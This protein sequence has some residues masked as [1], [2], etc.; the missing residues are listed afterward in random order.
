MYTTAQRRR[1]ALAASRASAALTILVAA[2]LSA[3]PTAFAHVGITPRQAAAGG[4][5][6]LSFG[7]PHGCDGS[8][9][10]RIAVQIPEGVVSVKPQVAPGWEIATTTGPYAEPVELH[11]DTLTEG[12]VEVVW[13]GGPLSDSHL[14][15]F[16]MSV[17]LPDAPGETIAFPVIQTCVEGETGWIQIAAASDSDEA[18]GEELEHPAPTIELLAASGGHGE[19]A[20]A[21]GERSSLASMGGL[22]LGALGFVTGSMALVATRRQ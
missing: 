10:T 3:A 6:K 15:E 8:S 11:G 9:T 16:G 5:T 17:R 14:A 1:A 4:Y 22:V 12:V 13:E 18:G 7:V 19:A 21:G 20:D 2:M